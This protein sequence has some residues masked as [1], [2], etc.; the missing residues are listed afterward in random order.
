MSQPAGAGER[1]RR[2]EAWEQAAVKLLEGHECTDAA[3][4]AYQRAVSAEREAS[5]TRRALTAIRTA[6][7][8][9]NLDAGANASA[10]SALGTIRL[11]LEDAELRRLEQMHEG[12]VPTWT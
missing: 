6:V 11:I 10:L 4:R 7:D 2:L 5:V 8:D 3:E 1:E 9:A 12:T